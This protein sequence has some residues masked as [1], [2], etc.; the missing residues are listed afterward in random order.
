M[1]LP[2]LVYHVFLYLHSSPKMALG[3]VFSGYLGLLLL[4]A[5]LVSL[6]IF[7]STLTESQMVA[8]SVTLASSSSSG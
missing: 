5:A 6:G 2:T 4:G 3:P 7:I 1:L 8:A